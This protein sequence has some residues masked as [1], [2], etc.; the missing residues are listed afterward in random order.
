MTVALS[1]D[2]VARAAELDA[3]AAQCVDHFASP[4]VPDDAASPADDRARGRRFARR[5]R[6]QYNCDFSDDCNHEPR[7]RARRQRRPQRLQRRSSRSRCTATRSSTRST[8]RPA[9]CSSTASCRRR[10]TTRATTATSR[11]TLSDDGDPCDVL[12]LSPVPLIT[13]V[14]VRCRPIGM[15]GAATTRRAAT[16]KILAVPIDKLSGLYRSIKSPR[17]LPEITT[18][19]IAHF[20][21]H[22]KDL[23]P[24]KWVRVGDLGRGR[25]RRSRKSSTA[26]RATRPRC[27]RPRRRRARRPRPGGGEGLAKATPARARQGLTAPLARRRPAPGPARASPSPRSRPP[28]ARLSGAVRAALEHRASSRPSTAC[29]TRR[30]SRSCSTASLLV[31]AL[32]AVVALATRRAAGRDRGAEVGHVAVAAWLVHGAYLGGVFVALAGGMPAGT[33]AMLVGLQPLLTVLLARALARRARRR[34]GSG[35]GCVLG[36]RRRL[37]G[38]APQVRL[39]RRAARPAAGGRRAGRDQRRHALPEALL[40]PRRP[41]H[42]RGDPVRRLRAACIAPLVLRVRARAGA[43][44]RRVRLRARLVGAGALGR[45]DQPA[46]LAAAPRR[47]VERRAAV[48]PRAAGDGGA[49]LAGVRR[50]RSTRRRSPAWC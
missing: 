48:L 8:R 12:V 47:G 33:I 22:Y 15:L 29:P 50:E 30:R 26:S 44:D 17:D 16:H 23:E 13:G 42:R 20:F 28:A 27:A 10:C 38:R 7:P 5:R 6:C 40:H 18:Q 11:R 3:A 21:E 45:R 2:E 41:A 19:Q 4:M 14:V 36:P 39:R 1:G 31:A 37:A 35:P 24:G 34:R 46:L 43:L 9:R 25:R 49:G 32:M